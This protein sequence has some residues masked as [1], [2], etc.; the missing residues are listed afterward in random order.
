MNSD[1]LWVVWRWDKQ[2]GTV[3]GRSETE[4]M[5]NARKVFGEAPEFPNSFSHVTLGSVSMQEEV[6]DES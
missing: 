3:G 2:V 1:Q 6:D 4:A 5:D